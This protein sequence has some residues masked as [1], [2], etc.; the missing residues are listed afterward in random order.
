MILSNMFYWSS[1]R[2][3]FNKEGDEEGVFDTTSQV[4]EGEAPMIIN[5]YKDTEKASR[6]EGNI[7]NLPSVL[8]GGHTIDSEDV[9]ELHHIGITVVGNNEPL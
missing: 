7:E 9:V 5:K 1:S 6:L 3:F 4:K 8:T 2:F